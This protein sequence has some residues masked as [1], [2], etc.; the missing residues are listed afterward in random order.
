MII[1]YGFELG[2]WGIILCMICYLQ[3]FQ[4]WAK[5]TFIY[6]KKQNK[7]ILIVLKYTARILHT[8]Y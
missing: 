2:G 5:I 6:S 1:T 7:N 4:Q 8:R 3:I